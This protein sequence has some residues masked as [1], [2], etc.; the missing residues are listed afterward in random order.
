M[1]SESAA[2]QLSVM[3]SESTGTLFTEESRLQLGRQSQLIQK[4][5]PKYE[6]LPTR[7]LSATLLHQL[8]LGFVYA[9]SPY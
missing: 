3:I 7:K 9:H 6:S 4:L 1:V 2:T 8:T 5:S